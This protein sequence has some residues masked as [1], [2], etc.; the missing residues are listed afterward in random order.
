[1]RDRVHSMQDV[2]LTQLNEADL[3]Q[4]LEWMN[5]PRIARPF[6]KS[7]TIVPDRHRAWYEAVQHD[8][9]QSVFAIHTPGHGHVGNIGLKHIDRVH[10]SGE[11]WIYIGEEAQGAG[12]ATAAVEA[13]IRKGF[14][15]FMLKNISL[16]VAQNNTPAIKLYEKV[17]FVRHSGVQESLDFE[18]QQVPVLRMELPER[19]W[20][21][22]RGLGPKVALMQPMFLPWIGYFELIDVVDEFVF[23]DDFQFQRQSWGHRNRLFLSPGVV[24]TVTLPI[25]H[26]HNLDATFL[27]LKESEITS[28]RKKFLKSMHHSYGKAS[29]ARE[30][31]SVIDQWFSSTY[32]NVA[33]LEIRFIEK[34]A[35]YLDIKTVL[36]RSST[37]GVTGQ[38]R[39]WRVEALLGRVGAGAYYSPRGSFGY[40]REDAVFPLPHVPVYFQNFNATPYPQVGNET[41]VSHLSAVDALC[42]VGASGSRSLLRGTSH[43]HDWQEMIQAESTTTVCDGNRTT[44]ALVATC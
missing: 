31:I 10:R 38:S 13:V 9:T 28:W 15:Q 26:Q 7:G 42:N 37:F 32:D 29:Y 33:D 4:T 41:F 19:A 39:S 8:V 40:M 14:E 24:G 25:Q 20:R 27:D 3:S 22:S 18:G 34:I 35:E 30:I 21:T 36:Q 2:T 17:G 16:R 12:F 5:N 11:L 6:L 23:L 44:G 43:W 1:M